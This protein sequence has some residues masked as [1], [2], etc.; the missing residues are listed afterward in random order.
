MPLKS[1]PKKKA[2]K[3][4]IRSFTPLVFDDAVNQLVRLF[5]GVAQEMRNLT[6]QLGSTNL[7]D[8]VGR[9]DLLEQ[10]Y[11]LDKI[12]LSPM[13][14]AVP[15]KERPAWEPGVGRLLIRPRNS[16]T[17]VITDLILATVQENDVK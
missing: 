8:L 4:G 2:L 16:L 3:L 10:K 7:Q 12:D 14:E 9:A 13:F 5:K 11:M 1:K 6:A 17:N 15:Y